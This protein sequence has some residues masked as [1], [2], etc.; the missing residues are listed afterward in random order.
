VKRILIT[1]ASG[2][3]GRH[4][5][6]RLANKDEAAKA[7]SAYTKKR[8]GERAE[9]FGTCFPERPEHCEALNS[10]EPAIKLFY[11]DLRSEESVAR[12]IRDVRPDEIYHLAALSQVRASWEKRREA[13]ETNLMGT[14]HLFEA[15]HNL[16]PSAR[17]LF[18]S[19]SDVYGDARPRTKKRLFFEDDRDGVVSPYAFTK[20]A[21]ELLGEFYARREKLAVVVARPFPHTGP[22]QTEV[23]VCSDWAR[24]IVRM[25]RGE[26][27]PVISVGN[28]RIRRDYLDVRDVVRAYALLM[29]KG[30]AGEVYNVASGNAP[31]L[32]EILRILLSF[33]DRKIKICVDPARMRK[34]DIS[35]LAGSNSKIN[36]RTGWTPRIP[37]GK[38]LSDLLE[39]WRYR[40]GSGPN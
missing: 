9:F 35:Y 7:A 19:S 4:L 29:E 17:I 33:T 24:Q 39:Y 18:V 21:G 15:A 10:A 22:G 16:T 32:G 5:I 11:V 34:S 13:V 14:F 8:T 12:L 40:L 30:K 20:I 2:F 3:V 31:S 25:E 1:G 37:L 36:A 26:A 38:T 28:L 23:F 27:E 6:E